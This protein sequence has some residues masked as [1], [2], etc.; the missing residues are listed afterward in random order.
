MKSLSGLPFSSCEGARFRNG[1]DASLNSTDN[2]GRLMGKA[3]NNGHTDNTG[4]PRPD[5]NPATRLK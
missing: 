3:S 4:K 1:S 2:L 5:E